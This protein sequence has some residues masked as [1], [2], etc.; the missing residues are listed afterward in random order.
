M[1]RTTAVALAL[2]MALLG[3]AA[4]GMAQMGTSRGDRNERWG[5]RNHYDETDL[6]G[7]WI[8]KQG[9]NLPPRA[10]G[11]TGLQAVLP[12]RLVIDQRRNVIRVENFKGRVLQEIVVGGERHRGSYRGDA[13]VGQ[14]RDSKLLT[15]R[16]GIHDTRV[17][18]TFA[19]A[20]RGR[21][22]VVTT[23]QDGMGTRHDVEFTT[24]YQRA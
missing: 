16:N 10:R 18:Q 22:L 4:P 7:R 14:W 21:T 24:V 9:Y 15:V 1:K 17:V 3:Q 12:P 5:D 23:R 19:L 20:N 13:I 6:E 2:A 11:G 8:S